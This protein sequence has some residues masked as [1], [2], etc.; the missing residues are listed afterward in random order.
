M[1]LHLARVLR[2]HR[3]YVKLS[4]TL[5]A[6]SHFRAGF[7]NRTTFFPL[8]LLSALRRIIANSREVVQLQLRHLVH[9]QADAGRV[10]AG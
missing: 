2:L 4:S 7:I 1:N 5:I 9:R 8:F 6:G 10:H 3:W